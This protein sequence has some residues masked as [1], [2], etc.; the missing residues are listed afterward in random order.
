MTGEGIYKHPCDLGTYA[1]L[2]LSF[3]GQSSC[4]CFWKCCSVMLQ[5]KNKIEIIS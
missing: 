5:V 3:F 2:S 4:K 1:P